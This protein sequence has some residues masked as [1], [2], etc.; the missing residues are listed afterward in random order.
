MLT[1]ISPENKSFTKDELSLLVNDWFDPN[2]KPVIE[3]YKNIT[4]VN[5]GLFEFGSKARFA[6]KY[7]KDCPYEEIVY[8]SPTT[9]FAQISL[10]Y[11]CAKYNKKCVLF[12]PERSM[13]KLHAYQKKALELGAT[14]HWVTM[15]MSNV[16]KSKASKYVLQNKQATLAPFGFDNELIVACAI[17]TIEALKIETPKEV[18][19]VAGSG[20]LSRCLQMSFPKSKVFAVGV[21]HK[22]SP[23]E[24][25]RAEVF[26]H[27]LDF[28]K[29][30]K[31]LPPF[32][33]AKTYDAKAWEYIKE[34]KGNILFW[35]VAP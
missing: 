3:K 34:R 7:I 24:L 1:Y 29:E 18:W 2:E 13:D 32:N 20:T 10:A 9:G 16:L 28:S 15:G 25:G 8:A 27:K 31:I 22:L 11:T 23:R 14:I 33:S 35:N 4:V 6:D 12:E 21:G 17:K 26:Y 19:S 5:D 30:T